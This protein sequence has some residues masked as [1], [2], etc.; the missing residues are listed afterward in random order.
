MLSEVLVPELSVVQL[1]RLL[2]MRTIDLDIHND[3]L[4]TVIAVVVVVAVGG[5]DDRVVTGGRGRLLRLLH[6]D[7]E[8]TFHAIQVRLA[9]HLVR[10]VL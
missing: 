3:C 9:P 7:D 1:L 5:S 8:I 6:S 10:R 4:T 2:V